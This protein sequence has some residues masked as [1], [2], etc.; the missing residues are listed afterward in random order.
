M[1]IIMLRIKYVVGAFMYLGECV[2]HKA[3]LSIPLFEFSLHLLDYADKQVGKFVLESPGCC[4][5]PAALVTMSYSERTNT[6]M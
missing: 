6:G 5:M 4:C 1:A 3:G 2:V